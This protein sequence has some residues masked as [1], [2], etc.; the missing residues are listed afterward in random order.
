MGDKYPHQFL[1]LYDWDIIDDCTMKQKYSMPM[2]IV[3]PRYRLKFKKLAE[4]PYC[5]RLLYAKVDT[6]LNKIEKKLTIKQ[7]YC[8][9]IQIA[10]IVRLM[11]RHGYMHNDFHRGNIGVT[12]TT[13]S[14][15]DGMPTGGYI[16]SA[17]DYGAV[18]H[19]KFDLNRKDR[20]WYNK[21]FGKESFSIMFMFVHYRLW[22]YLQKHKI[23]GIEEKDVLK[24]F[25]KT[26]TY[27]LLESY[28][29]DSTVR[30]EL[31][32]ILFPKVFQDLVLA[33]DSPKKTLEP[34]LF[35]PIE[36]LIF[37]ALNRGV[38]LTK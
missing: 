17:I 33:K 22:D 2:D 16:Y 10:N 3:L 6:S 26:E 35:I 38:I 18:L 7:R 12:K 28:D 29:K 5:S 4:S 9:I 37:I 27:N 24:A 34:I 25:K 36:D 14:T 31:C 8:A 30:L 20:N 19:P 15:I 32:G 1:H 11:E 21:V 13:K 23:Q